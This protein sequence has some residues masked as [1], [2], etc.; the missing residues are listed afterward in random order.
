MLGEGDVGALMARGG[1]SEYDEDDEDGSLEDIRAT[2]F[3]LG[4]KVRCHAVSRPAILP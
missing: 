2:E 1:D 3:Y 4:A